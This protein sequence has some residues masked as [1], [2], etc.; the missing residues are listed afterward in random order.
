VAIVAGLVGVLATAAIAAPCDHETAYSCAVVSGLSD[1]PTAKALILDTFV[2]SVVD[3]ADPTYLALRYAK[4]TDA[5][6]GASVDGVFDAIYIGG[7]GYTLPR[8]YQATRGARAVVLE[9]DGSLP[10]IAVD[11]LGLE[12]GPWLES[13]IGDARLG[14][15]DLTPD[16]YAVVVGDAFSGRSVPWHLTT[17]EFIQD[18]EDRMTVDG[19]YVINVIDHP[20][21]RF[22]RSEVATMAQVFEHVAVIA[23]ADYLSFGRGGNFVLVGSN[24]PI[25]AEAISDL[26]PTDEVILVDTDAIAWSSGGIV[27]TDSF[28]PTDQLLSRP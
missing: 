28:A 19:V 11:E 3:P 13:R 25:D 22:A 4:V 8:F 23:P 24:S 9:L 7:G 17:A 14:I 1:H 26:L 21:T 6:V 2:N 16:S 20:P 27:L 18:I 10:A 12:E 5:V 15:R